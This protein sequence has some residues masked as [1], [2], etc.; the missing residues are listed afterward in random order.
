VKSAQ[1]DE[2]EAN[3]KDGT[4]FFFDFIP[5]GALSVGAV[6]A[7]LLLTGELLL[8]VASRDARALQ[9]FVLGSA[10]LAGASTA[11]CYA[12]AALMPPNRHRFLYRKAGDHL[13][14]ALVMSIVSFVVL[15]FR[16]EIV[17]FSPVFAYLGFDTTVLV[18]S[19]S[20]F[21]TKMVFSYAAGAGA[22]VATYHAV[23]GGWLLAIRLYLDSSSSWRSS[24][25]GAV[26]QA[27]KARNE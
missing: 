1:G 16:F 22:G 2:A 11:I 15:A 12:R 21:I 27:R 23:Y 6:A 9:D 4:W 3:V 19:T 25:K 18:K 7:T 5:V 26:Q 10:A 17:R 8:L 20:W 14:L 24:A 13:A